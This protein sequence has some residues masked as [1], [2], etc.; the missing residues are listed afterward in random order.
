MKLEVLVATMGQTDLSLADRM[1]LR[2]NAVIANQCG[3]WVYF[4][5]KA[6][7]VF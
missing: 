7:F 5:K 2:Q 4:A 3:R 6:P 1:N